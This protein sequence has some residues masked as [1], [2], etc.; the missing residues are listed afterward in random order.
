MRSR[1]HKG[2]CRIYHAPFDVRLPIH[3]S[4]DDDKIL[5]VVQP[6]ICVI[7]DLSKLDERG[8]IGAPDLVVEVLS[9]STLKYD[10]NYKFNLY[11]TAGVKEYWIVDPK[12]KMVNVFLL[13]FDGKYDFGTVYD[14]NQKAPVRIFEGLEIDLKELFEE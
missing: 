14:C 1:K 8:C 9:P 13:Q 2:K 12:A 3:G 7:C 5:D 6:D 4:K 10:W 11:E